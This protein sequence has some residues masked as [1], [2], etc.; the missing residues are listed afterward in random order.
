M[1]NN[2]RCAHTE[3]DLEPPTEQDQAG[4]TRRGTCVRCAEQVIIRDRNIAA[5]AQ[6]IARTWLR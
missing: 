1:L 3:L 4:K 5:R 2:A 6:R